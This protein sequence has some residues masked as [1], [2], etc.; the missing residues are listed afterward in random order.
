[1]LEQGATVSNHPDGTL[2]SQLD[3]ASE[4]TTPAPAASTREA[5]LWF[6]APIWTT[7]DP[8]ADRNGS[9]FARNQA[10]GRE[11]TSISPIQSSFAPGRQTGVRAARVQKTTSGRSSLSAGLYRSQYGPG[12]G[13]A[14]EQI[15]RRATEADVQLE[16]SMWTAPEAWAVAHR[17]AEPVR[18]QSVGGHTVDYVEEQSG[19][20]LGSAL[21]RT[22]VD[23]ISPD[24]PSTFVATPTEMIDSAY[25][26]PARTLEPAA[27]QTPFKLRSGHDYMSQSRAKAHI[28]LR[29]MQGVSPSRL[30]AIL[31]GKVKDKNSMF[32]PGG[33][34]RMATR[35]QLRGGSL[36]TVSPP[37][38]TPW[39]QVVYTQGPIKL[40]KPVI[41]PRKNSVASLEP[42]QEAV[43]Q[44]YQSALSIPR[45][46]SDDRVLDDV[47]D[48]FDEFGFGSAEFK[49]DALVQD[50][51]EFDE[52]AEVER[53]STPPMEVSPV[54]RAIAK[55][56]FEAAGQSYRPPET[57]SA[58]RNAGGTR[59][60][61]GVPRKDSVTLSEHDAAAFAT[62]YV[63]HVR[64]R[65]EEGEIQTPIA[66]LSEPSDSVLAEPTPMPASWKSGLNRAL[67]SRW[68]AS[69]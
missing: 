56:I 35:I 46:R 47:C 66:P 1:M 68:K 30:S 25:A 69:W 36:L 67:S 2:I 16:S 4:H 42:F 24:T 59:L 50:W 43:E 38:L 18:A 33:N 45:R 28:P 52:E 62:A 5:D 64:A 8:V 27:V 54:E 44:M 55:R 12:S 34:S 39:K 63:L 26:S 19:T 23:S 61:H 41:I 3:H 60:K 11:W 51:N 53:F 21:S 22:I 58:A 7:T 20:G 49:G 13:S 15:M 9:S 37:E 6:T 32:A 65:A 29:G 40:P 14:G 48:F 17:A 57:Y 10:R 31:E